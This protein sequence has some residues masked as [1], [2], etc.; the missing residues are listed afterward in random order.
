[1]AYR[2]APGG[3]LEASISEKKID[4]CQK[5]GAGESRRCLAGSCAYISGGACLVLYF[6]RRDATGI[7]GFFEKGS[8]HLIELNP[9]GVGKVCWGRRVMRVRGQFDA[10]PREG[11]VPI[12]KERDIRRVKMGIVRRHSGESDACTAACVVNIGELL[13]FFFFFFK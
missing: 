12:R 6:P 2:S 4:E 11:D 13:L 5:M 9:G 1:M 7:Q 10:S 3:N 8:G